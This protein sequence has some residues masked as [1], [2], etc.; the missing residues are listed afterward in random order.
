MLK[1]ENL[2]IAFFGLFTVVTFYLLL[3]AGGLFQNIQV[4]TFREISYIISP[5]I[6]QKEVTIP[7]YITFNMY[8]IYFAATMFVRLKNT[9]SRAG[10]LYLALSGITGFVLVN[11]PMDPRG[12]SESIQGMRHISITLF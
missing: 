1:V 12:V 4:F 5:Y 11:H 6:Y 3:H 9:Y 10:A 2:L 8:L 7:L